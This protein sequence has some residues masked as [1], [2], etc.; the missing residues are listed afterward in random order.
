[1]LQVYVS[2]DEITSNDSDMLYM[3]P[4]EH[5]GCFAH[6]LQ[7]VVKDGFKRA[8]QIGKVINK[9]SKIVSHVTKSVISQAS[10]M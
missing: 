10:K 3:L 7:L 6:V 5:H 2:S 9:C 1:M 8:S 4:V